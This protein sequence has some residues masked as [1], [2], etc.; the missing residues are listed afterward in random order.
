MTIE[1]QSPAGGKKAPVALIVAIILAVG[2][3]GGYFAFAGNVD[4]DAV[5]ASA[6]TPAAGDKDKKADKKQEAQK[7]DAK[8]DDAAED[9]QADA[10]A[11][12]TIT[13]PNSNP[14]VAVVNG[15][16]I[17][18]GDVFSFITTLPEQYRQAPIDQ[19]FPAALEQVVTNRILA[20]HTEEAKL[21]NDPEVAKMLEDAKSQI[22]R[23]VYVDR[24]IS[25]EVNDKALK[26][27]Y[28]ELVAKI[29]D[30]QEIKARHILTDSEDKA[31]EA[32]KELDKGTDFAEVVKKYSLPQ[33]SQNGGELGYFAKNE[34]VPEFAEAAFALDKGQYTK[35]PVKTQFGWHVI[36]VEDKRKRP[37]P[38]FEDVKPQI[39]AQLRQEIAV[40]LL[41]KWQKDAKVKKFDINGDPIKESKSN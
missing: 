19:L 8:K 34:M 28:D 3:V 1:S 26:K 33:A 12:T 10:A 5:T 9:K 20:K 32:I 16:E 38:D 14:V 39:E 2:A 17:K 4:K 23:N 41:K 6:V 30:V 35:D 15:E 27:K 7:E 36:Q 25:A 40:D 18:R 31:K 13:D 24:Q 29:G 22:E 21:E 11:Q 37:A